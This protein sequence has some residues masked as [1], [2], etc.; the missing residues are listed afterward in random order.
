ML[1]FLKRDFPQYAWSLRS[2]D[3]RISHFDIRR[4][5]RNVTINEVNAAVTLECNGPGALL[6]YRAMHL[7]TRHMH[8]L[9]VPRDL[10]VVIFPTILII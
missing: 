10:L 7:K 8:G 5:N 2:L 4:V 3:R 9:N 1:S 6:G